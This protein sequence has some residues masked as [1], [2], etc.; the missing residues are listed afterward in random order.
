VVNFVLFGDTHGKGF[1]AITRRLIS[2]LNRKANDYSLA[3]RPP[4][5]LISYFEKDLIYHVD[6]GLVRAH[7]R[8]QIPYVFS[9]PTKAIGYNRTYLI[10]H[11]DSKLDRRSAP[12][13]K[14]FQILDLHKL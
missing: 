9:A 5:H 1:I 2:K 12:F 8:N 11:G 13:H 7:P 10:R 14:A 6:L 4:R 3:Q